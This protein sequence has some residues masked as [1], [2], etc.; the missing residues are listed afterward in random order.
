VEAH[1]TFREEVAG[2]GTPEGPRPGAILQ[3]AKGVEVESAPKLH[4]GAEKSQTRGN[5]ETPRW[6]SK[7]GREHV[8]RFLAPIPVPGCEAAAPIDPPARPVSANES[9]LEELPTGRV[10]YLRPSQSAPKPS[11]HSA[12]H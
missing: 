6:V 9:H 7:R 10:L 8:L 5:A 4:L 1:R 11:S 3:A 2:D 12:G